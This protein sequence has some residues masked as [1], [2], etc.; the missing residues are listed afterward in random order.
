MTKQTFRIAVYEGT[1]IEYVFRAQDEMTKNHKETDSSII[2]AFMPSIVTADGQPHKNCPLVSFKLYIEHLNEKSNSLWQTPNPAAFL[3]GNPV[4]FKNSR[5][6]ECTL[7]TFMS[8]LSTL[9]GLSY[10]YT[11][12]CVRVTGATNLTRANFSS[13]QIMSITG[14]KSVNSLAMYQRVNANEKMMMGMSLAFNLFRP[15]LVQQQLQSFTKQQREEIKHKERQLALPPPPPLQQIDQ[16]SAERQ[17][18][19]MPAQPVQQAIAPIT[20]QNTEMYPSDF[21]I[22]D[23]INESTDEEVVLAATQMEKEYAST[24]TTMVT[25]TSTTLV[26]RSPKKVPTFPTFS[27]CQIQNIHFHIHKN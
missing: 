7:A 13:N 26:K 19:P 22:L 17:L 6:G 10:K 27:S 12:H 11:N 15:V 1:N 23:F 3:K 21:D 14:H 18:I 24:T 4:W 8:S 20:P 16:N 5:V 9:V 2:T 25:A